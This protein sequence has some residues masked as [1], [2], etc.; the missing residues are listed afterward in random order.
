MD[1]IVSK[2]NH[3]VIVTIIERSTNMLFMRKLNKGKDADALAE[4][5]IHLLK[6][7][8]N[9]IKTI[10]TD[11]ELS[12]PATRGSARLWKHPSTSRI[13]TPLGRKE[14]LKMKMGLSGSTYQNQLKWRMSAINM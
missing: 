5:V 14:A 12:S 2:N 1:T 8:K 4:V 6:P 7:F 11:N 10:T 3:G 9:I 13:L